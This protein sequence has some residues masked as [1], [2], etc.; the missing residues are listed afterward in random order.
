[1]AAIAISKKVYPELEMVERIPS[2]TF[3]KIID[4]HMQNHC[5]R[6]NNNKTMS[7]EEMSKKYLFWRDGLM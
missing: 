4:K 2:P 3:N 7:P 5:S 1:M 6:A